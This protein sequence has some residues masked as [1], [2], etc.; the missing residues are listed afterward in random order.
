MS[1]RASLEAQQ[2]LA[3]AAADPRRAL[4]L[5]EMVLSR[6]D[7]GADEQAVAERAAALA[8][9][10]LGRVASSRARFERA[11]DQAL[12]DGLAYR[13]PEI[14]IGLAMALLQSEEPA[15]A[16]AEIDSALARAGDEA[17]L[18]QAQSQR[19]TILMRL[20]RYPEAL[21]Q[22]TAALSTCRAAQLLSPVARLLSNQGV[23]HAYLGRYIEA[24]ADLREALVL[25]R[26]QGSDLGAANVVHNLG[27]VAA[28][29]GD[30]PAAL[31][32]FDE[33]FDEYERLAAVPH[34]ALTDRCEVLMS[35]RLL[36][37]ARTAARQAVAGLER[38]G[39]AAD[40]A[41]ARLML[42]EVALA[43]GDFVPA[44]LQ[45]ERAAQAMNRQGRV[46]W[47][48]LASFVAAR[49]RWMGGTAEDAQAFVAEAATLAGELI[50]AGWRLHA[51]E[52]VIT[53]ARLALAAGDADRA[54]SVVASLDAASVTRDGASC[55]ERVR[56]WYA[57]ALGQLAAGN[58]AE[59]L[60]ALQSGL[61]IAEDHRAAFG[62]T[63]LRAR[64]TLRSAELAELGLDMVL[65]DGSAPAVLEW[66]ERWRARSLWPPDVLPPRDP[67]LAE[68]LTQLRHTVAALETAVKAG[69]SD[70]SEAALLADR[71]RRLEAGIRHRSLETG[72]PRCSSPPAPELEAVQAT[73]AGCDAAAIVE[74]LS[75]RG[76]LHAVVC[77]EA[78]CVV[79]HLGPLAAMARWRAALRFALGR[80]VVGRGSQ[81]S[82]L[83]A[84][85]LLLRASQAT[86][87]L[88]F[89]PIDA[90]LHGALQAGGSEVVIV[91]T[92]A[93]HSLPWAL[94]PSLC[95]R[96][97]S[98]APSVALFM[99]RAA[100]TRRGGTT[101]LVAG[102]DVPSAA[103]EVAAISGLYKDAVS[104]VG[105]SA[106]AGAV[107]SALSGAGTAH[108]AAHGRFRADNALFS[109]LHL[110]DGPLTVYELE[111]LCEPPELLVLS[112]CD[113]G[114]SDVQPGDELMG[115]AAAMLSLGS[116][117]IVASV[118]PVPDAGAPA[119]MAGFH[120]R[121]LAGNSPSVALCR[122]QASHALSV[123]APCELAARSVQVQEALAAAGFVCL[124]A[125][126]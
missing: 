30:V 35:V 81:S 66:S 111:E 116:R 37:E 103:A 32:L 118:V 22:A 21:E 82:L 90:D 67:V 121:L 47:A 56:A 4:A 46:G 122:T 64:A 5:A 89:G 109:A 20:G 120:K 45:A 16:M 96:P 63:E 7:L 88:L 6:P 2:A 79:R 125:G 68:R 13:V 11:R 27:F 80:L 101:V 102:P 126:G 36:P 84:A 83:A 85:E 26:Q 112:S 98:V 1:S 73:L 41:E 123:F 62:A 104:L 99:N 113:V 70:G 60:Q 14:Q 105:E 95:G 50:G 55:D 93:L 9:L 8:E 114:R 92:G 57:L 34:A 76:Q 74:F 77:T 53:A 19:A 18:G 23:V 48:A 29:R 100:R 72:R 3:L 49:A 97:V 25:L 33:A 75:V 124:G 59:A 10:G 69:E 40:L 65:E 78:S 58:R 17:T 119:V 107:A 44:R 43:S 86:D 108:I 115:A 110:A 52:A 31:A 28:R 24:E 117:A 71:R 12:A 15:A 91:P 42:A 106:T 39:L 54:A 94:L 51:L 87:R 61:Q 38:A